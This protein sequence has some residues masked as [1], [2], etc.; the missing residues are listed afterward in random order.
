V[1]GSCDVR[2]NVKRM[3]A[4]T[5]IYV[6]ALGV[7]LT[8]LA[9]MPASAQLVP[10]RLSP[11]A[12]GTP[13]VNTITVVGRATVRT[14]A[15][16]LRF[17]LSIYG[18]GASTTLDDAGKAIAAILREHG[19]ADAA[20]VL[21]TSGGVSL[22]NANGSVVGTLAKPTREKAEAIIRGT[23]QSLPPSIVAFAQ[24]AQLSTSL[25]VDDCS[26]AEAR[27]QEAV[28]ADARQRATMVARAAQL[29]LGKVVAVYE[30]LAQT[31]G[32]PTKPD[33]MLPSVQFSGNQQA[34]DNF[35]VV[36]SLTATVSFAIR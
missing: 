10:Q 23:F 30:P 21:P 9:L 25:M 11:A 6:A 15:D 32:C 17:A 13:E 31:P 19:V 16:R 8:L 5:I 29:G 33:N 2:E 36:F 20:W 26:A 27:A 12:G 24:G 22:Q 34:P 18:R 1:T 14:P 28:I 35:D 4:R 3:F 7:P